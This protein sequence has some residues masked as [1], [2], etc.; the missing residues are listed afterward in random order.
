M[1]VYARNASKVGQTGAQS[2]KALPHLHVHVHVHY[3]CTYMF[4]LGI[5]SC[6]LLV[7]SGRECTDL[8]IWQQS[9]H[10]HDQ[11]HPALPDRLTEGTQVCLEHTAVV[12]HV[13]T[14]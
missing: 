2:Y 12:Q 13:A 10:L 3:H 7:T 14:L 1:Y 5:V 6:L 11:P 9:V 8:V 4:I